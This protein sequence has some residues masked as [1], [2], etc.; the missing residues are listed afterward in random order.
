MAIWRSFT[1]KLHLV[2]RVV[3]LFALVRVVA[4]LLIIAVF[5]RD[6]VAWSPQLTLLLAA[7]TA[8]C[9]TAALAVRRW[10]PPRTR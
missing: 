7:G 2:L 1:A 5:E 10:A 8:L 9:I 6:A 3:L 4:G